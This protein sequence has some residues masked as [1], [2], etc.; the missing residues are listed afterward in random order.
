MGEIDLVFEKKIIKRKNNLVKADV[1]GLFFY[2]KYTYA[3]S[4][5]FK[6]TYAVW[7]DFWFDIKREVKW[8]SSHST[9]DILEAA[10][11]IVIEICLKW[12]C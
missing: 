5:D 8:R 1:R 4:I 10:E 11:Q 7:I 6:Y 12:I 9:I 3:V 2:F